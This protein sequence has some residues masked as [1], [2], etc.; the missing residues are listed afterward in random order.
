MTTRTTVRI[1]LFTI[2][3]LRGAD[4][5]RF[6]RL[7]AGRGYGRLNVEPKLVGRPVLGAGLLRQARWFLARTWFPR[8]TAGLA[9]EGVAGSGTKSRVSRERSTTARCGGAPDQ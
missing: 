7:R 1:V 9:M 4:R 6:F 5:T 8:P 3:P 2:P